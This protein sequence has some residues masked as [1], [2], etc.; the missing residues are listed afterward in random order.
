MHLLLKYN[1]INLDIYCLHKHSTQGETAAHTLN[2]Y[3]SDPGSSAIG[4]L[5]TASS[6][7]GLQSGFNPGGVQ[8][9]KCPLPPPQGFQLPFQTYDTIS[10]YTVLRKRVAKKEQN[11]LSHSN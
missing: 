8:G 3:L 2:H 7:I 10:N 6:R 1:I 9:S 11:I 4:H 5:A